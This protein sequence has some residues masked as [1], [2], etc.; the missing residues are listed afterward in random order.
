MSGRIGNAGTGLFSSAARY[1]EVRRSLH[2]PASWRSRYGLDWTNFFIADVQTGFG[3]F[4]AF[5]LAHLG[6]TKS[7]VG[8]AL[9][10]STLAS[11]LMLVP[12]GALA[13]AVVSKRALVAVG[14]VA[15]GIAALILA[16]APSF[17][18]VL[19]AELLHGV[20]GG[21]I[22]P[23]IGAISLGL[24]GRSAMSLRTG[25][26]FR[27]AAAG[28]ALTAAIMGI[29]GAYFSDS[30]IFLA[31]AGLCI[32][33]LIA[34]SFIRPDEIDYRKARNAGKAQDAR[35]ARFRDLAKNPP[36][37]LFTAALVLFQLADASMLPMIGE[38]LAGSTKQEGSLWMSGLIIVPQIVVAVFAPWV[39][40]HSERKGRKP[41]LLI[42]FA[43]EP[44]RAAVLAFSSSYVFLVVAQILD[45]VTGAIITVLTV[46][47]ITDLTANTGRF[48]FARG[49]VGA[50]S[51]LAAAISTLATGYLFQG[52]GTA[53]GFLVICVI[54]GAAT[55]LLW[56]FVAETKPA[57]YED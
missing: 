31:A 49:F 4:V 38:N 18:A 56:L 3:T 44:I 32:P 16:L 1:W 5:Y 36:L 7:N 30:G 52:Y 54:A 11:V 25:R 23:A 28:N 50:M 29:V 51:G 14:I 21:I 43:L 35:H 8:I 47:V 33:A 26:N 15:I 27:Y 41:L 39:G 40:Y 57:K 55:A 42:G 53:T 12:G 22:T 48:N 13:D 17:P 45:G 19:A 10:T 46:L 24:V 20:T 34:L 2:T 6:W 37:I 9:T